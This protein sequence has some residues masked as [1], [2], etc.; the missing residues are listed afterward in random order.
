MLYLKIEA[1]C[2]IEKR[3]TDRQNFRI[4][5]SIILYNMEV[6]QLLPLYGGQI[7]KGHEEMSILFF[8]AL[9]FSREATLLT[10]DFQRASYMFSTIIIC[11][12]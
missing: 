6:V 8:S 5:L 3:F 2:L 1:G 9:K 12:K 7:K 11:F 10:F 4:V